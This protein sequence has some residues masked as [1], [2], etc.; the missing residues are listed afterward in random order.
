M[1]SPLIEEKCRYFYLLSLSLLLLSLPY[2][3]YM[4]LLQQICGRL[5]FSD[6]ANLYHLY[7]PLVH[8]TLPYINTLDNLPSFLYPYDYERTTR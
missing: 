5:A 8:Y 2:I 6:S 1:P 3:T 4:Y 7:I